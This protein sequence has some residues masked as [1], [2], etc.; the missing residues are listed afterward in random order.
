MSPKFIHV[1][2]CVRIYFLFKA[3]LYPTVPEEPLEK[4]MATHSSILAWEI[5]WT[6]EPGGL[7]S[8]GSQESDS[9]E[10]LSMHWDNHTGF[11]FPFINVVYHTDWSAYVKPSL[12]L[13]SDSNLILLYDLS[14]VLLDSVC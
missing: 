1:A 4:E 14:Y 10:W 3:K 12:Q 7:Q 2:A 8:L 13:W 9:A 5:P 6:E 11:V